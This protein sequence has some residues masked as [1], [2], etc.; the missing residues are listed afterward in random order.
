[1]GN[2]WAN[3][4]K[5]VVNLCMEVISSYKIVSDHLKSEGEGRYGLTAEL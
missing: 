5:L 1:M 2:L 4:L 3:N